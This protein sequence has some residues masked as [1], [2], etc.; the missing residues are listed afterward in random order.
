MEDTAA[1]DSA[2]VFLLDPDYSEI[3][4]LKRYRTE[5]LA[6]T[7]LADKRHIAVDWST[8]QRSLQASRVILGVDPAAAVTT[9]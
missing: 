2:T 3:V 5:A 1:D 6:K 7:G 8:R 9:G 4:Y